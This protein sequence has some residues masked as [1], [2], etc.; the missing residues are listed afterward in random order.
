MTARV[1][2]QVT[3]PP[4]G[5]RVRSGVLRDRPVARPSAQKE[6]Q[7]PE[8]LPGNALTAECRGAACL[9]DIP[10]FRPTSVETPPLGDNFDRPTI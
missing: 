1:L 9:R 10:G 7:R 6:R 8:P 3:K 5:A 2:G 4:D